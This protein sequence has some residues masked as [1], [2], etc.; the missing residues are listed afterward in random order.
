MARTGLRSGNADHTG[1]SGADHPDWVSGWTPVGYVFLSNLVIQSSVN[2]LGT[3]TV[4]AWA[5]Y[6]KIDSTYWM[7]INA[8]GISITTFVGQN[9]GARQKERAKKWSCFR[10]RMQCTVSRIDRYWNR[11]LCQTIGYVV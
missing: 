11:D 8:L 10:Y 7:I 4:A 5:A 3:D 9:L 1:D 2:A 6:G